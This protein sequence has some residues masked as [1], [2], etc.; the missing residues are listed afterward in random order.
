MDKVLDGNI[1]KDFNR[2]YKGFH[3]KQLLIFIFIILSISSIV[4]NFLFYVLDRV[5][6]T[7]DVL[8]HLSLS[9]HERGK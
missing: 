2:F 8:F 7:Y 3:E 9:S 1:S 6:Y 5:L 4:D